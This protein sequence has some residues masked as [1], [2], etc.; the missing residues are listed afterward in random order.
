MSVP[1]EGGQI[2]APPAR[3]LQ[4]RVTLN[5]SA[6]ASSPELSAVDI[7]YLPK[8]IAP[9]VGAIEVAPVQLP[10]AAE[11]L[12]PRALRFAVRLSVHSDAARSWAKALE[13][14]REPGSGGQFNAAVQQG[15]SYVALERERCKQ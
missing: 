9:K 5:C 11:H 7:A 13:C 3:F 14:W 15:R 12:V 1:K 2:E 8:N 4:Y 10:A 6:N